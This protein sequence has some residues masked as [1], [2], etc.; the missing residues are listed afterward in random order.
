[1][2]EQ[3]LSPTQFL[4]SHVASFSFSLSL[5]AHVA[6]VAAMRTILITSRMQL[7]L[8]GFLVAPSKGGR[9]KWV[10]HASPGIGIVAFL[11]AIDRFLIGGVATK[12]LLIDGLSAV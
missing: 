8:A 3:P 6:L 7:V 10:G 12:G 11:P 1:M 4:P 9:W 5:F 2:K